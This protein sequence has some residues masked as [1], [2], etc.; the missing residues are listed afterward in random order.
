MDWKTGQKKAQSFKGSGPADVRL[1]FGGASISVE[2]GT[3]F[4]E[5]TGPLTNA[6]GEL[7]TCKTMA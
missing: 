3:L 2:R 7:L 6:Y 1:R 4:M 5:I